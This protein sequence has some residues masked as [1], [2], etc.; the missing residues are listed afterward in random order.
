MQ[1]S[2]Q[3]VRFLKM[4]HPPGLQYSAQKIR[5][6]KMASPG[7]GACTGRNKLRWI[8]LPNNQNKNKCKLVR[9]TNNSDPSHHG[10]GIAIQWVSAC[11]IYAGHSM[12][13]RMIILQPRM[14]EAGRGP[15]T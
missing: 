1:H 8:G 2:A 4:A 14:T 3:K 5:F 10:V 9:V 12:N 6:L 13:F 11:V 15:K 7:R